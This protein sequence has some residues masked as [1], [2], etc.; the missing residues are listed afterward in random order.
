[1]AIA[2]ADDIAGNKGLLFSFDYFA[3][4]VWPAYRA[5][6]EIIKGNGLRAFFHSDGDM[7]K[8][9][10][11]LLQ[12]GYDCIHPVDVQGGLDPYALRKE[13]GERVT[14]MGHIDVMTWDA[15]RIRSEINRAEKAFDKGGLISDPWAAFPWMQS[16][17]PYQ[18]STPG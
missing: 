16:R 15:E 13:F 3:N 8:V 9:I 7:R 12:A 1:M 2:L 6:G 18:P 14:F 4:T 10:E 11:F 17:R 5:I